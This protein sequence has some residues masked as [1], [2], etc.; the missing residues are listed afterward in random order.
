MSSVHRQICV[1]AGLP[2]AMTFTGFRHGG[3]TEV[4]S[5]TA[6]V[7]SISGHKTLDVTRI[8]NQTNQDFTTKRIRTGPA[9]SLP[10]AVRMSF[11]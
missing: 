9:R 1:E 11:G 7:R 3:I 6:D 8:Y 4:G 5:V 2:K 10:L